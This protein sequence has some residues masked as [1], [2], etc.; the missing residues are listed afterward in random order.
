MQTEKNFHIP[1][2]IR[3]GELLMNYKEM[4]CSIK[5]GNIDPKKQKEFLQYVFKYGWCAVEC[6]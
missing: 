5:N 3:R 4:I 6:S 2:E 1:Y